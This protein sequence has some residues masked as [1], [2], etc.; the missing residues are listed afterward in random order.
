MTTPLSEL[1][2]AAAAAYEAHVKSGQSVDI[3]KDML[4][5]AEAQQKETR[6]VWLEL[7]KKLHEAEKE[8]CQ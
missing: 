3:C 8:V 6:R 7:S 4:A 1:R 5:E 2:Q